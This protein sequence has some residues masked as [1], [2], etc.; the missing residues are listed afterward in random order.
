M[1]SGGMARNTAHQRTFYAALGIR[2]RNCCQGKENGGASNSRFHFSLGVNSTTARATE[3][4]SDTVL[5]GGTSPAMGY[6]NSPRS[7][8]SDVFTPPSRE[9]RWHACHV[10]VRYQTEELRSTQ[11]KKP[12]KEPWATLI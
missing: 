11:T 1:M 10:S 4:C 7:E 9:L 3:D 8:Q 2:R 12:G 5:K 6:L